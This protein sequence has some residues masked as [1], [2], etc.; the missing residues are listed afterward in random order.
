[1]L[2]GGQL[3]GGPPP[4]REALDVA[5]G[6]LRRFPAPRLHDTGQIDAVDGHVLG[7]ADAR[8]VP[9]NPLHQLG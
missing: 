8:T 7:G 2:P 6:H 3:G 5:P 9:G 4:G 1:M